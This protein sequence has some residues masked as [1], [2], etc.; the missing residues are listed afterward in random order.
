MSQH[1]IYT[2]SDPA[3][4]HIVRDYLAGHGIEAHIRG[5][6]LWGGMGEL[7]ANAYPTLWV[8]DPDQVDPARALIRRFEADDTATRQAWR[9]GGCGE[10]LAGQFDACWRCGRNRPAD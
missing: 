8:T 7:P 3:N 5:Q 4:A 9:C 10:Q 1:Q 6:F 2:A